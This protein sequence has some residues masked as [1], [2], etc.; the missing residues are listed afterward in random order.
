VRYVSLHKGP[1]HAFRLFPRLIRLFR[2]L[3]PDVV[4]TRNLAAL[5]CQV[6]AAAARVPLRI[7][8]EHGRDVDDLDGSSRK[9]QWIRRLYLPFVHHYIALSSDLARYLALKVDVPAHRLS[10]I[11]NGVDTARFAPAPGGRVDMAGCPFQGEALWLV[12]T[13]GR[14]QAVKHQTLLARAFVRALE[15]APELHGSLR[16]V[17]VGEGPLR[18]RAQAILDTAGLGGLAWLPGERADVPD[19]MRGLD[20]FVLPSLAEGISNTIL[21]AMSCGLPVVATDVGGNAELVE[22]GATGLVVPS[23][24]VEAMAAALVRLAQGRLAAR[25]LGLAARA[26]AEQRYSLDAMVLA[27]HSLY[28]RL[29]ADRER[30]VP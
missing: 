5:E 27:Y 1:G 3:R 12:G 4:H 16:L 22:D 23:D 18:A 20:V 15:L 14:M 28:E 2:A 13:V 6:A 25:A 17:M 9:H 29:L 19:V 30:A 10:E 24:D 26:R 7:H 8:G 11:C 21:E